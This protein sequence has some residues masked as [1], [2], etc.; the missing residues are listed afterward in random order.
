MRRPAYDTSYGV[1]IGRKMPRDKHTDE[2][3]L[4]YS[5]EHLLYEFAMFD[6][7]AQN[8]PGQTGCQMSAMLQA[9][10]VHLRNLIDFFYFPSEKP[11]DMLAEDF[12]DPERSWEPGALSPL[13]SEAKTR[14]NKEIN[15]LTYKRKNDADPRKWW[16]VESLINEIHAV[17]EQFVNAASPK[18]LHDVVSQY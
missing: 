6:W 9:F 4:E 10:V 8:F 14:A 16:P 12:C 2:E 1:R 5:R 7:S 17:E 3:L 11:D 13:L 18:K 15:H